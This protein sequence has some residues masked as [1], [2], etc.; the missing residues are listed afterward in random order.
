MTTISKDVQTSEATNGLARHHNQGETEE[1]RHHNPITTPPNH[2]IPSEKPGKPSKFSRSSPPPKDKPSST[3]ANGKRTPFQAY[4]RLWTYASL[5][6]TLLRLLGIVAALGAGTGYPLMTIVFG[7]LVN[8]FNYVATGLE[9]PAAFRSKLDKNALWFVYLFAGKVVCKYIASLLFSITASRTT[10]RIRCQYLSLIIH[11]PISY[12]DNQSPG[13]LASSL[14][15]D[16]NVIE[17]AMAEKV[18]TVFQSLSML[19]T[20]FVIGMTYQWKLALVC[21][22]VIPYSVVSTGMLATFTAKLDAEIRKILN[23]AS[24]LAEEALSSIANVLAL[25]ANEKLVDKFAAYVD[26]AG[27]L[28]QWVGPMTSTV[29]GNMFFA[30]HCVYALALFYGALLVARGEVAS[31]G[32]VLT[33]VP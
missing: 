7:R 3:S 19:I 18:A 17:V 9:S 13:A 31:G 24:G 25:D 32:R 23:E 27:R 21:A 5:S 1:N 16:P 20:A 15:N 30:M 12:F 4:L 29:Y 14:A 26:A 28:G 6:D 22:V 8:D 2:N 11:S 10:K 33:Y